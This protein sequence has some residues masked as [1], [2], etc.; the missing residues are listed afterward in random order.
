MIE[1]LVEC[2]HG[3]S[4]IRPSSGQLLE[5]INALTI[6]AKAVSIDRNI[7]EFGKF[8]EDIENPFIKLCFESKG[9]VFNQILKQKEIQSQVYIESINVIDGKYERLFEQIKEIGRGGFG[10]VFKVRHKY[11]NKYYAIKRIEVICE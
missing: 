7:L 4:R 8:L 5:K 6:D 10:K 1:T 2:V 3:L 11:Q 9:I